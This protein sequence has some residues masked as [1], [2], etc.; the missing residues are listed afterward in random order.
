MSPNSIVIVGAG[1]GGLATGMLLARRGYDVLIVEKSGVV[2]GRMSPVQVGEIYVDRGP[3]FLGMPQ[4]VS[5]LFEHCGLELDRFVGLQEIDPMYHLRF[6]DGLHMP[7]SR[8]PE[9]MEAWLD[10]HFPEEIEGYRRFRQEAADFMHHLAPVLQKPMFR[11]GDWLDI[12]LLRA[13][14]F[15]KPGRS[16]YDQLGRYFRSEQ[17]KFAFSFQTKYLGMSPWE[18]PAPFIILSYMEHAYGVYHVRG[19]LFRLSLAMA[20]AFE[21]LGGRVR[22]GTTV[23]AVEKA[24]NGYRLLL[25]DGERISAPRVI[26]NGDAPWAIAHLLPEIKHPLFSAARMKNKRY[27]YS[28]MMLYL[29]LNGQL[30]APHHTI[31]FSNDYRR[32]VSALQQGRWSK[33]FSLYMC[34]PAASDKSMLKG[35]QSGLYLLMP[36]PHLAQQEETFS[37]EERADW[38]EQ[39]MVKAE[40]SGLFGIRHAVT[41]VKAFLPQD[42]LS[43]YHVYR[44]AVFSL[45]H[46][47]RQMMMFRPPNRLHPG[48]YL[49]GGGTHPG[50][51]LPTIFESSRLTANLILE[52]D[53][54]MMYPPP[55]LEISQIMTT[56]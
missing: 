55:H 31:V 9:R 21:Q 29:A 52:E 17:L 35:K 53:Q 50:S 48:L 28:T 56:R 5:S 4:I 54:R 12:N 44:G 8:F 43:E 39:M 15:L 45:S 37:E 13:L 38:A 46:H 7:V 30:E 41:D 26:I 19:G 25:A 10:E 51:G 49:V 22:L 16:V 24:G 2:G 23:Q 1:P 47:L 14:P 34:N 42:W 33:D 36:V 27:S 3:T 40:R 6:P 11:L 20:A 18:C 32:Y